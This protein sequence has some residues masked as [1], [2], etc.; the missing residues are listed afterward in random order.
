MDF[1][2]LVMI[3]TGA[4]LLWTS[5]TNR[6]PVDLAKAAISDPANVGD[7]IT[8]AV[9]YTTPTNLDV[10]PQAY[11]T[12]GAGAAI[13][14][15]LVG[16]LAALTPAT[17]TTSDVSLLSATSAT[18]GA[19]TG[20]GAASGGSY[21]AAAVAWA[22]TQLGKPYLWGASG[23]NAYDCSGLVSAAYKAAGHDI[24]RVTTASILAS[25]TNFPTVAKADM[26]AGD[27][28]FPYAGHVALV[29]DSGTML[30]ARGTVRLTPITSI[31]T[32]RRVK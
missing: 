10:Y 14:N 9:T 24:G 8:N 23:P 12:A 11:T 30:E 31:M 22:R 6:K 18:G 21:G 27:L 26:Q 13:S 4:Y 1:I 3:L 15:A 29:V 32:I 2:G 20:T 25:T 17:G 16:A 28:L 5:G 19:S 7:A